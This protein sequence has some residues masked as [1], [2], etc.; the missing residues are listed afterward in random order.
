MQVLCLYGSENFVGKLLQNEQV[1]IHYSR[2]GHTAVCI[3]VL[4]QENMISLNLQLQTLTKSINKICARLLPY[5]SD[6][7]SCYMYFDEQSTK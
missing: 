4:W 1:L 6:E 5:M 7:M 3:I 2:S